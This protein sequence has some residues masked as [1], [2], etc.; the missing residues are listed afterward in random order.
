MT[1]EPRPG[2]LIDGYRIDAP[3]GRGGMG[4]VFRAEHVELGRKVAFKVLSVERAQEESFRRRFAREAR[5][6]ARLDH[7]NVV[8]V[9]DAGESD[10]RPWIAMEYVDGADLRTRIGDHGGPL[11]PAE[12][13]AVIEQVAAGL[14]HA[15]ELGVLH[16]D[17]KPANVLLAQRGGR[18]VAL[19]GDFG[20]TKEI[21]AS[22]DLTVS[23]MVV[24][25]I[26]Y[27]APES[28]EQQDTD[29]RAD[30]YALAATLLTALTG[31]P[32]FTGT[33]ATR[34]AAHVRAP[35]PRPSLRV[36]GLSP[37]DP[38]IA[39]GLAVD[40]K[41]R[42]PTAGDFASAAAAA[43]RRVEST[44]PVAGVSLGT[45]LGGDD[46]ATIADGP[47]EESLVEVVLRSRA[48]PGAGPA[49]A[50]PADAADGHVD[51]GTDRPDGDDPSPVGGADG[52]PDHGP[53]PVGGALRPADRTTAAGGAA[54][55]G[56]AAADAV[57][58]PGTGASADDDGPPG[59]GPDD[60]PRKPVPAKPG[61]PAAL[62]RAAA[63]AAGRD[64]D[65]AEDQPLAE[66]A[67]APVPAPR[68]PLRPAQVVP[69]PVVRPKAGERR[70]PSEAILARRRDEIR[71]A[72]RRVRRRLLLGVLV[73]LL[74]AGAV[75]YLVVDGTKDE[76]DG[77]FPPGATAR[78]FTA[79]KNRWTGTLPA[80]EAGWGTPRTSKVD[81]PTLH[82]VLQKG[83]GGRAIVV[84]YTSGEKVLIPKTGRN[85]I[86]LGNGNTG[87]RYDASRGPSALGCTTEGRT[88]V[89]VRQNA[90]A[91][92]PGWSVFA[93]APTADEAQ[94][95][96]VRV[97][98]SLKR[99]G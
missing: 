9:Y 96:A 25:S 86:E 98:G 11:P 91:K 14:D 78:T 31:A 57:D 15:H 69:P 90:G 41:D 48:A 36:E 21:D 53:P 63:A 13:V 75:A 42:Y 95:S 12:A 10:D 93:V 84:D 71:A 66:R 35:R 55:V 18:T 43:L 97:A 83:P 19:L 37:F 87:W 89:T 4:V 29:A 6:A 52:A 79:P 24:G 7:P 22:N 39:R 81:D 67:R 50:P 54:A 28:I 65:G 30:V 64:E 59:S 44:R 51:A 40:P 17:V 8:T 56:G 34:L 33:T 5:L 26:D 47:A 73:V 77:S 23:G 58:G 72:E 20:L 76:A 70:G 61:S 62:R 32:P 16:R 45:Q 49:S 46:D 80:A 1:H 88:C 3:I 94:A 38:V 82:R 92:G 74:V 85:Q 99:G 27:L 68:E 2:E 60:R